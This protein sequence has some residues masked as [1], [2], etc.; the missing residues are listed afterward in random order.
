MDT[1]EFDVCAFGLAPNNP[2]QKSP[3]RQQCEA[4]AASELNAASQQ[5]SWSGVK[6]QLPHDVIESAAVGAVA[7]CAAGAAATSWTGPGAAGGCGAGALSGAGWG[8]LWGVNL[9]FGRAIYNGIAAIVTYNNE[10]KA[11]STK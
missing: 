3:A 4:A 2:Q 10:M 7:G 8:A 9:T 5:V 6:S 1:I 11:C